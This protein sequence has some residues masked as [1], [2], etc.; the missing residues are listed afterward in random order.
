MRA[1]LETVL[2]QGFIR[3]LVLALTALLPG[4]CGPEGEVEVGDPGEEYDLFTRR[5][6]CTSAAMKCS[7]IE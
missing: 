5:T 7:F 4:A 1:T 3:A 6:G 2:R